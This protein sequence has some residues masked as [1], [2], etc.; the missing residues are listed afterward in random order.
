ML[1]KFAIFVIVVAALPYDLDLL[2]REKF[3][4][5]A[6]GSGIVITGAST[7]IGRHAAEWM[8]K[9]GFVVYAG[10]RKD[11]DA[12]SIR[13][14]GMENLVPVKLDVAKEANVASALKFVSTDLKKR[15]ITLAGLVNN[16]GV[17]KGKSSE[18]TTISDWKWMFDINVFG[19]VR[20][21]QAFLPLLRQGKGRIVQISSVAGLM[22]GAL[23]GP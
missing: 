9:K 11:S 3:S 19:V 12:D 17:S 21:T 6:P 20:C 22:S 15:G 13:E 5:P 7:G 18:F 2:T 14:V 1:K 23:S 8:A 16:A 10:V 4:P